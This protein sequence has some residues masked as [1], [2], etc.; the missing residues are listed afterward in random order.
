VSI[1]LTAPVLHRLHHFRLA[2]SGFV[3]A[4]GVLGGESF[5]ALAEGLR[6][7]TLSGGKVVFER[8]P[9]T[10]TTLVRFAWHSTSSV[11]I[12]PSHHHPAPAAPHAPGWAKL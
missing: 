7:R 3:H 2:F 11:A 12:K 10:G 8:P 5:V 1:A 4:H 6:T 9:F